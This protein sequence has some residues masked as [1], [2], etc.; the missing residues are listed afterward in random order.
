MVVKFSFPP[1]LFLPVLSLLSPLCF[2]LYTRSFFCS[3]DRYPP[4]APLSPQFVPQSAIHPPLSSGLSFF[5]GPPSTLSYP[6]SSQF[7]PLVPL[8]PHSPPFPSYLVFLSVCH[9][10]SFSIKLYLTLRC[11]N[12]GH[13]RV[14][15][16]ECRDVW[17]R[18]FA[19]VVELILFLQRHD[20]FEF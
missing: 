15:V 18:G 4:S 10:S 20:L 1:P 19:I 9:S 2:P 7:L 11:V 5:P 6:L 12:N 3:P 17:F 13:Q 14:V 8:V 16:L